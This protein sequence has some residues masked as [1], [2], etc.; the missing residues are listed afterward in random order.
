MSAPVSIEIPTNVRPL[1]VEAGWY[2]GRQASVPKTISAN[3]PA[4][5]VLPELAG[6]TIGTCG[7]GEECAT[8]D[9]CFGEIAPDEAITKVWGSLLGSELVGVAE[10]H[11]AHETLYVDT[12]G[13]YFGASLIHDAFWFWGPTF[14]EAMERLLL[15]RRPRPML[16]PDQP[17]VTM[18]GEEI[19]AGHPSVYSYR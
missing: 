6:L 15:G 2:L 12:M 11:Q 7:P 19:A 3:H 1:F 10:A 14:G 18:Y 5:T 4:A 9:V 17:T 13:R 16:R 8:S